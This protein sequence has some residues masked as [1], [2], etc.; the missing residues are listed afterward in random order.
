MGLPLLDLSCTKKACQCCCSCCSEN[1]CLV[2]G[3][4][5]ASLSVCVALLCCSCVWGLFCR[6]ALAAFRFRGTFK[7]LPG[8]LC[9][10]LTVAEAGL[11]AAGSLPEVDGIGAEGLAGTC[12]FA[13]VPAVCLGA[14]AGAPASGCGATRPGLFFLMQHWPGLR[15]GQL[16]WLRQS[17]LEYEP[18][19]GAPVLHAAADF[20]CFCSCRRSRKQC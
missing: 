18:F 8:P 1:A 3:C 19:S 14:G 5:S 15:F 16:C 2:A 7:V 4:C 13:G 20:C 11:A 10:G 12:P 17:Q 9:P 6:A